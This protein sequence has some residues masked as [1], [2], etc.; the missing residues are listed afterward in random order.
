MV[1]EAVKSSV[2]EEP[3][4]SNPMAVVDDDEPEEGEIVGDDGGAKPTAGVVAEEHP[5]EHSWTFWFDNRKP[6]TKGAAW[7][8]SLRRIYTFSTVEEFWR[9]EKFR[10]WIGLG[11]I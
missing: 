8:S 2:T 7:G 3:T 11:F 5:L 9:V 10:Q 4:N 6:K 1:E